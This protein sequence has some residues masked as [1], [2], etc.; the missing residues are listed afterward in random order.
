MSYPRHLTNRKPTVVIGI[1]VRVFDQEFRFAV[2]F[3]CVRVVSAEQHGRVFEY[4]GHGLGDGGFA[5]VIMLPLVPIQPGL[6]ELGVN[7]ESIATMLL[8]QENTER[9]V[10]RANGPRCSILS[11]PP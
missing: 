8:C 9:K 2:I 4:G 3:H 6:A 1:T 5:V 7:L 10:C 11:P